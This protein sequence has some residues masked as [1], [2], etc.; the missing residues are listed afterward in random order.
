MG[1]NLKAGWCK[2]CDKEPTYYGD[3]I[4]RVCYYKEIDKEIKMRQGAGLL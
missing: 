1:K 3:K 4:C 2:R